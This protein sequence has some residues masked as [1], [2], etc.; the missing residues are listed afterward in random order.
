ML[1]DTDTRRIAV[2]RSVRAIT[3]DGELETKITLLREFD[4][5]TLSGVDAQVRDAFFEGV[6]AIVARDTYEEV[7]KLVP[8]LVD[9]QGA[10]P[11]SLYEK[12]AKE[13]LD[14]SMSGARAGKP[15]AKRGLRELPEPMVAI[16]LNLIDREFVAAL[17]RYEATKDFVAYHRDQVPANKRE[18]L[19]D[20]VTLSARQF[21][22]KYPYGE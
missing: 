2:E 8:A 4:E 18:S 15:A 9:R 10:V 16:L 7:N 5:D 22:T 6:I 1:L 13:L 20:L 17:N 14:H 3:L 21:Y 12:Y 19:T 11:E